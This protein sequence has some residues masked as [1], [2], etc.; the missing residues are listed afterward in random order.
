[1]FSELKLSPFQHV[2]RT[3]TL[4]LPQSAAMAAGSV[5]LNSSFMDFINLKFQRFLAKLAERVNPVTSSPGRDL[6]A[7]ENEDNLV[8]KMGNA[9]VIE[10]EGG[11]GENLFGDDMERPIVLCLN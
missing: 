1:M 11:E 4:P 3:L 8:G 7:F 9:S 6:P 10:E 5:S 2:L